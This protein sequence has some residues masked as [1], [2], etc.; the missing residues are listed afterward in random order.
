M[1][2]RFDRSHKG[3]DIAEDAK[4]EDASEAIIN[5]TTASTAAHESAD[6]PLEVDC[7]FSEE[8]S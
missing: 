7:A 2:P 6:T 3:S 5:A 4:A 1:A 8:A